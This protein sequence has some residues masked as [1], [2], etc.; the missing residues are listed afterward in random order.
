MRMDKSAG[1]SASELLNTYE[2]NDLR[3]IFREYGEL[4]NASRIAREIIAARVG[5]EIKSVGD[6]LAIIDPLCPI[7][8]QNKFRAQVFQALRMEV[9]SEI[10]S[11][12]ELLLQSQDLLVTG[13][14]MVVMSYHSLEDRLV[15]NFFRKGKFEGEEEK[16]LYGNVQKPF[17]EI[18]RRPVVPGEKEIEINPRAR[19]A[20]LRIAERR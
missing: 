4:S 5:K 1:I 7:K 6:L 14:R 13:G 20:K 3:R 19:S 10:D 12:K 16:D 2:F 11:L 17:D 9:N 8:K 18:N 15:K